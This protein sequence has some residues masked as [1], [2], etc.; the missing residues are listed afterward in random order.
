MINKVTLAVSAA[1]MSVA[2]FQTAADMNPTA[3]SVDTLTAVNVT[4]MN[5]SLTYSKKHSDKIRLEKGLGAEQYTYIVR[6]K[7]QA[8]ALY[9]GGIKGYAATNPQIAKKSLFKKLANSK[10]SSQQIRK[11]LRLDLKSAEVKAY[12]NYLEGKQAQFL[13]KASAKLGKN[14]DVVYTYKNVFNGMA[15]KMSQ[16]QAAQLA[17]LSDVAFVERERMEQLETDTGPIHIG[18]TAVWQ[19]EGQTATNM[20]EGVIIGVV[21]TGINSD[22]ASFADIGGDGYDHTNPWGEGVYVGDCAN[23]FVEMCNDKL[24]GVRSYASVTDNYQDEAVFGENPPPANGEDYNGHGSHTAGTSGGNILKNV[25]M[26]DAEFGVLESDGVNTSGFE[27]GQISGVAPHANIVAYQIC[28]PGD[29]G[30]TYSGCPGAAIVAALEDAVSDDVDVINYSISGGGNPWES[31]SEMTFLAAQQAGIFSSVSAGNSGP[32]ASTTEKSAPWY[33]VVGAATHGRV[34]AFDKEVGSFTGGD[35]ELADIPGSSASGGYTGKI[36]WA[37]DY[38]NANDPDGDPAQC[39]QPFPEGTFTSGEIVVCDR[40]AIARVQKAINAAA[41][42][43]SGFVLANVDGGSNSVANDVYVVPGIHIDIDNGNLLRAW[44]ASGSDH[45]ATITAA[46]GELRI[47][48]A[49]DTADFSSRGPNSYVHDI[50]TP[51]VTA[52]GVSIYAASAD[53]QFGHDVNGPAPSD[54]AFLQG[55]SMSAPHVAGAGAVLKSSH[56]TWT[57]DNIRSA[58][59]MTATTDVRKED[60][61]TISDFFDMGAGRIRVDL[62]DKAGLIMN[63]TAANYTAANPAEGGDPKTL[64][65]PSV[66]N[67]NCVGACSWTRTVTATMDGTWTVAGMSISESLEITATPESFTLAAGESQEITINVDAMSAQSDVWSF[68]HVVMTSDAHPTASLPVSIKASKG[69]IPASVKFDA[70]RDVDGF[71]IKDVMATEITEFT[72]NSYGLTKANQEALMLKQDSSNSSPYDDLEDGVLSRFVTVP[73]DAKRFVAKVLESDSPDLDM[74]VGIDINGDGIPQEDEE[75]A[76]SATGTALES[77]DLM[78]PDAGEYWVLVMNGK[79]ASEKSEDAFTLATAVVDGEVG[80]NLSVE[81]PAATPVLTNFDLTFKW[82]LDAAAMGDVYFGAVDIGTSADAAG[83]LGLVAVDVMRGEDDVSISNNA[84]ARL[85]PGDMVDYEVSVL[86]NFNPEDR[87]YTITATIPSG[88]ELNADSV[89]GDATVDGNVISW[90][91]EQK[92]LFNAG[93]SYSMTTNASDANCELPDFGQGGG[94]IDL[95]AFGIAPSEMDGDTQ[96]ANFNVKAN[97]MGRLFNTINVAEDGFIYFTG[98]HGAAPWTQQLLPNADEA[99]NLIAPFWRDHMLTKSDVSGISVGTYD[100]LWTIV[101]FD[102]M[103][104]SLNVMDG[105]TQIDDILDFEVVIDNTSGNFMFA[106]E[107]VTHNF[108]DQLGVSIGYE[109]ATGTAGRSDVYVGSAGDNIGSV[110][111][112]QSGLVMCYS[113]ETV[114]S[115]P[116]VM[117]FTTQVT[118]DNNGNNLNV[119]VTNSVNSDFTVTTQSSTNDSAEISANITGPTTAEERQ[120]IN[121]S[122]ATSFDPDGHQLSYTWSQL[123]GPIVNFDA[124]AESIN[125][126]IPKI[127]KDE[128]ASFQLTVNSIDN[129]SSTSVFDIKFINLANGPTSIISGPISAE[130]HQM[131]T[132]TGENSSDPDNDALTYSWKQLT[133]TTVHFESNTQAINFN[134]PEITENQESIFELIVEDIDGNKDTSRLTIDFI[135]GQEAP[136]AVITGPATSKEREV[137]TLFGSDSFDENG[138]N[139][140]YSWSQLSGPPVN[141]EAIAENISFTVPKISENVNASFQLVVND[142]LN[143]SNIATF[144]L[145][146]VNLA[147]GPISQISGPDTADEFQTITLNGEN[148]IDPDG[149]SI[150]YSWQQLSGPSVQ[151]E[152]ETASI[153]FEIPEILTNQLATFE[154]TVVDIDGNTNS[155]EKSVEFINVQNAPTALISGPSSVNERLNVTLNGAFSTDTEGDPLTYKWSQLSGPEVTFDSTTAAITFTVPKILEDTQALFQLVVNDG[156]SDSNITEFTVHFINLSNEPKAIISAP[157]VGN[158]NTSVT[159]SGSNSTDPDSDPLTYSWSQLTGPSVTFDS[160]A[161]IISF[162]VPSIDN[163]QDASFKLTVT[164]IDGNVA[165]STTSISFI[166]GL[167][168][169]QTTGDNSESSGALFWLLLSTPLLWLRRRV[170]K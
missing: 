120:T 59:M 165:S 28:S 89:T 67:A 142:G 22:H 42:G 127:S 25:P 81:A 146:F 169:S 63:E 74:W 94:Y 92:S 93:P 64:N 57:P 106:Y 37:G 104:H 128:D 77:I 9:D 102:N 167:S 36:V 2:T 70:N 115:D 44:L 141:F 86:P 133:G 99:N 91:V 163:N 85:M 110:T 122:G 35:S 101:E 53:Q 50:M 138:D 58:L 107:N 75:I 111:D 140:T 130:E 84:E 46:E 153:N 5:K 105:Q 80:D 113:L 14:L 131:I 26:L 108:G 118:P 55:T 151:F 45:M 114:A 49:D 48:Q 98:D 56:P 112:I 17:K 32:N 134:V 123:S 39:L 147:N 126:A 52:P 30:D 136:V 79:S 19:G 150:T 157:S 15:V 149:D 61:A 69:N 38:T 148:S 121:L 33:T 95:L 29:T 124:I 60:G 83:N 152:S 71:V 7:D 109:N 154:L 23:G 166:N 143:N 68:G 40:G 100:D 12:S 117:T 62:A 41:G 10:K 16:A 34:V 156:Y 129:K 164:D 88:M 24:I 170:T 27:F 78:N 11:E 47:G 97:F 139:L 13:T 119:I 103:K 158:E 132:L 3:F 51:S 54:Y 65:I 162:V 96:S 161:E 90:T 21:D 66:S 43:A 82:N 4:S 135:N 72:S 160:S 87:T 31:S 125:F 1:L 20:G 155:T 159:L 137:M 144:D 168:A 73:A 18:A 116:K 6:L 8:V 145:E 76:R